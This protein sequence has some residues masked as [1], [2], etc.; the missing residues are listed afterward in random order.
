MKY[1]QPSLKVIELPN[2][3]LLDTLGTYYQAAMHRSPINTRA[4]S[5]GP[6]MGQGLE[7]SPDIQGT[8]S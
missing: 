8:Q 4:T 5:V 3:H 1:S 2:V 7:H 6:A